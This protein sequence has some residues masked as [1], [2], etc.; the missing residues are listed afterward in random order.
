[1]HATNLLLPLLAFA[2]GS[3][4]APTSLH[5]VARAVPNLNTVARNPAPINHKVHWDEH[6]KPH[7]SADI[8]DVSLKDLKKL[9]E[10]GGREAPSL[11]H[12]AKPPV[13]IRP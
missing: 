12:V 8:S 4:A 3:A 7:L 10:L 1:M 5:S 9:K 2:M 6:G 11:H 13:E